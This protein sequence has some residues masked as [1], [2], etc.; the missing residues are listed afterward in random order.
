MSRFRTVVVNRHL[1]SANI[2]ADQTLALGAS[3]PLTR[4]EK[5]SEQRNSRVE[6][7]LL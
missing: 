7:W 4:D 5:T 6:V 1:R 2:A 3:V